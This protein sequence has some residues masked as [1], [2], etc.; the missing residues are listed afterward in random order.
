MNVQMIL[1]FEAALGRAK[2]AKNKKAAVAVMR[3]WL[4]EISRDRR[5]RVT[6]VLR[7]MVIKA[8]RDGELM[9]NIAEQTG[10]SPPTIREIIRSDEK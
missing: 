9:V 8:N 7:K 2:Q 6:A 1:S 5:F 3:H 10:L 4:E